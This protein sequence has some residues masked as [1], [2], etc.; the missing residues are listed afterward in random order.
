MQTIVLEP[1]IHLS[2]DQFWQLCR[3]NPDTNFELSTKGELLVVPPVSPEGSSREVTLMAQVD[4]WNR[5]QNPG[6]VFS[7][8]TIFQLPNGAKRMPDVA[9]ICRDRYTALSWE[10]RRGFPTIAPDFVPKS[11]PLAMPSRHCRPRWTNI[12]MR[13]SGLS[14]SSIR[15]LAASQ[16][17]N[18]VGQWSY[19][20]TQN[21]S[22]EAR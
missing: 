21:G 6:I 13:V 11:A 7:S 1:A 19:S 20:T 22:V 10:E 15:K 2:D 17:I 5:R 14:F 4:N 9:W 3:Q 16:S 12:S 18:Q 8:P